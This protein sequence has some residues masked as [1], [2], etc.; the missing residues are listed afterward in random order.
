M[1]ELIVKTNYQVVPVSELRLGKYQRSVSMQKVKLMAKNFDKN[2]LGTITVSNRG[3]RLYVI[4]GQ[5][6]VVLAR[7]AGL[8]ELMALV[9]EG[10]AYEEEAEYFNK[11]NGANGEQI[12]LVRV[13]IFNANVEAKE[14][15][16]VKIK[17]IVESL[18]LKI[19]KTSANN[20]IVA[21]NSVLKVYKK[22]GEYGLTQTLNILKDTWNG[23]SMSFHNI[24]LTGTAEFL[25]IYNKD[26]NF[27]EEVFIKQLSKIPPVK[28]VREAKNDTTTN[29]TNVK[30]MNTL[31]RYY[32]LGLRTKRL[33][34]KH[35]NMG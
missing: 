23:E 4:D 15:I 27:S 5:H 34:N 7:I 19:S 20:T 21:I 25:N 6:R 14:E 17:N 10:L 8:N 3:G 24:M 30:V 11:L 2:L 28:A 18:G 13:D 29:S 1:K 22:Y 33:E 31:I 32:N 16:S 26:V 9:Y 35:Y 12:R